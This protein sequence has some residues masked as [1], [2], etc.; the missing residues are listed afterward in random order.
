MSTD[1]GIETENSSHPSVLICTLGKIS[2]P[3]MCTVKYVIQGNLKGGEKTGLS[4]SIPEVPLLVVKFFVKILLESIQNFQET[5][6]CFPLLLT[7]VSVGLLAAC[8]LNL[9]LLR[10]Y[11]IRADFGFQLLLHVSIII[12]GKV[13]SRNIFWHGKT[14]FQHDASDI[15]SWALLQ[16]LVNNSL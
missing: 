16:C 9:Q 5:H 3:Q 1:N 15:S 14:S 10:F 11:S 13:F 7:A 4:L 6:N 8:G 12:G 2:Y